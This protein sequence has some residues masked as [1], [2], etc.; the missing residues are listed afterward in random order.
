MDDY[1]YLEMTRETAKYPDAKSGTVWGLVY[2]ALG[3][4][5]AGEAQGKIKKLVRDAG[6]TPETL[7]SDLPLEVQTAIVDELGDID[8]YIER[9]LDEMGYSRSEM[10]QR[11][12]DKLYD[13]QARGV[14]SG[15]GDNR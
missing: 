8:W 2:L 12:A 9:M 15:S 5:E 1:E 7:I 3:L 10:R 13:R 14:I 4:G 6:V 11:N